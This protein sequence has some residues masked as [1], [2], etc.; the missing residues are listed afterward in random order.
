[1]SNVQFR[2]KADAGQDVQEC[3]A[4][5]TERSTKAGDKKLKSKI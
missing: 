4:M 3:D 1:M 2:G 5:E